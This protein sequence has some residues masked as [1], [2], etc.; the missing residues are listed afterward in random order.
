[1][2]IIGIEESEYSQLKGPANIFNKI[3]EGNF[4]ILKEEMAITIQEAYRTPNRWDQKRNSSCHIMLKTPYAQ[5]KE[6]ILKAV[7]G[8]GQIKY[9]GRQI[10]I[11]PDFLTETLRARRSWKDVIQSPTEQNCQPSLLYKNKTKQT[12]KQTNTQKLSITI[13]EE[14]K[15]FQDKTIFK[16]CLF[17]NPAL[18]RMIEGKIHD[19]EV[20]YSKEKSKKLIFLQQTQKKRN[21]QTLFNL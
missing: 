8:K 21:T 7:R 11:T 16:Q 12:N 10:R 19:K 5:N 20:N 4:P 18:Q 17:T 14:T 9:K 3:I 2:R 13:D 1:L 6:I 15:V